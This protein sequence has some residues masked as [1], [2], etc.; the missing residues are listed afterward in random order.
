MARVRGRTATHIVAKTLIFNSQ[1]E[2]LVLTRSRH[3]A[4]RPGRLDFPG[5]QV[6]AGEPVADG[7]VREV[8][9]EAG[10]RL[11]PDAIQLC[12]ARAKT[13]YRK[14]IHSNVNI[15]WLGY[16]SPLPSDAHIT[17]SHEHD[18]Y[19]WMSLDQLVEASDHP[20]HQELIAYMRKNRIAAEL[21]D[22]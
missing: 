15:V 16:V 4:H 7:A 10:I 19:R 5:G 1:G 20:G 9:E 3:D 6:E 14:N 11:N 21:W 12:F 8:F 17:L 22:R 18:D 2:V 13:A